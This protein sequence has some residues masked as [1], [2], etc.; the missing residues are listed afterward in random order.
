MFLYYAL[1]Y[2]SFHPNYFMYLYICMSIYKY[3][4]STLH[5][6]HIINFPLIRLDFKEF[7]LMI[8][9]E[10]KKKS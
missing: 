8:H 2:V 1:K 7:C 3:I 5:P 4:F 6:S 9:G 10:K